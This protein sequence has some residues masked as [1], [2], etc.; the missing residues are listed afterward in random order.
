MLR[1]VQELKNMD[2]DAIDIDQEIAAL[3]LAKAVHSE[4]SNFSA[5][6]PEWLP[7]RIKQ[8]ERDI[9]SKRQ[10]LIEKRV[11]ELENRKI[12]LMPRERKMEAIDAELEMLKKQI[13]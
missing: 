5:E 1:I 13:E 4:Y 7:T 9:R 10:A 11:R 2:I 12:A 3:A 6:P 8:L